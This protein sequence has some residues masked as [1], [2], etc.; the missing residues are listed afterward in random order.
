MEKELQKEIRKHFSKLG[1][2]YFLGTVIVYAVQLLAA[3]AFGFFLPDISSNYSYSF[4]VTMLAYFLIAAPIM[5]VLIRT[6]K[7]ETVAEKKKMSV[8][9]WIVAFFIC[10]GGM[11]V[12]N[13]IGLGVTSVV[14]LLKQGSVTNVLGEVAG[15]VSLE[16]NFL[17]IVV[18]AP[19]VEEL[20]FRKLLV[21]RVVRFGE[22]AA[23]VLSGLMFGLYH[24][25]LNQFIYAFFLG[26]FFAFIYVRTRNI[27]HVISIHMAVNF[28]GTFLNSLLMEVS[29]YQKLVEATAAGT[30][31]SAFSNT[32]LAGILGLA[33]YEL[34]LFGGIIAGIIL[35]I[36]NR[37]KFAFCHENDIIPKG[38]KFQ[39][40]ILNWGMGL[41]CLFFLVQIVVQLIW[42]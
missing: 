37:K 36:V 15:S 12:C 2:R 39:T 22:P 24:G 27:V 25:N 32:E 23:V 1:V 6:M 35:M 9:Q 4:L 14:G 30:D 20:L 21:D 26:C 33:V 28:V 42:G 29:N 11:Y 10:L 18:G 13:F 16:V 7:E 3:T 5:I 34:I 38:K 40:I 19:I 41:Y 31:L 17:V 8:G